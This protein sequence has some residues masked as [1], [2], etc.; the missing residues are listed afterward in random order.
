M[1]ARLRQAALDALYPPDVACPL[2]NREA[3]LGPLGLCDACADAVRACP[4]PAFREPLDGLAAAFLYDGP[5]RDAIH[6]FKYGNATYLA[7]FFAKHIPIP[8]DW[9]PDCIVP[10]PLYWLRQLR[11][12]YNQSE[13]LALALS[14]RCAGLPV[15]TD[16]IRRTRHTRSQTQLSAAERQANLRGAFRAFSAAKG[17]SILLVDDVATTRATLCACAA[18]LKRHGAKRVYAASACAVFE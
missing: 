8:D 1:M 5:A 15:R 9:K 7:D 2:C 4:L 16:L 11:R 18:Q 12:G 10:V 3:T 14:E 13:L 6:R 17:L